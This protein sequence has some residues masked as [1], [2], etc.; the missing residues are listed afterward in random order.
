MNPLRRWWTFALALVVLLLV[1]QI[2]ASFLVRTR[3]VHDFLVAQLSRAFGRPVEVTHFEAQILPSPR[4][5]ATAISVGEDPAFGNEY[6]LRAEGFSAGLRWTG[7]LRGHFEFGTLAFSR[8]SLIL[9]RNAEGRWNLER[10]LPGAKSAGGAV[11]YGPP[12]AT[13]SNHLRTIE[14]DD[15]RVNFKIE[16]DKQAF[17]FTNVAGRVEQID[18]GRW[19]LRLE[20]TPW[21]SGVALQSTGTLRVQ[22]D[23]AG[24]SARLQPAQIQVHW[25][26]A[27]LADL[28]RLWRGQDYGVRGL[29]A[30][31]G[32]LQSGLPDASGKP[33]PSPGA[34][35]VSLQARAQRMHRWDLAERSD[36][37][38]LN[39][40]LKGSF[41][42]DGRAM[43]PARFTIEAPQSNLHGEFFIGSVSA[44]DV[45]VRLDSMGV[46][47]EDL[48]AWYR[49]FQP[50]VND[51]T[52]AQQFF[53]GSATFRGWPPQLESAGFSSPGGALKIPGFLGAVH[54]GP[55][56][57]GRERSRM[58]IEPVKISWTSV[59]L[60]EDQVAPPKRK[61]AA[62]AHSAISIG[63]VH[64]FATGEGGLAIEGR[65]PNSEEVLH[66]AQAFGRTVRHGWDMTGEVSAALQWNWSVG[67]PN[68]WNGRLAANHAQLQVAGLNLPLL[69]EEVELTYKEGR[70]TAE[71]AK[72]Q[73]FG[74]IWHGQIA[75]VGTATL[76]SGDNPRWQFA[77]Q[78][79]KLNAADLD[80]WVGPRARPGWLQRLLGSLLGEANSA[81]N[82][83]ASELL[84]R[85][86]ADG[87]LVIDD[88]TIEKLHLSKL[89]VQGALRELRLDVREAEAQWAGGAVRGAVKAQFAPKVDYDVSVELDRVS[90]AQ[91]PAPFAAR[92]G[93]LASGKLQVTASGVGRDELLQSLAGRAD[94]RLKNAEL[95]GW[96]VPASMADGAAH[97]GVTRWPAGAGLLLVRDRSIVLNDFRLGDGSQLML[98]NGSITFGQTA[99]LSME[100]AGTG[101]R[102]SGTDRVLRISGP[103]DGPHVSVE[104]AGARQPAD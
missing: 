10:W 91:L 51:G 64:D 52:A 88:L 57:G 3:R 30:L 80:R 60:K 18:S 33:Q 6:F 2:G 75:E 99:D 82:I 77:L 56:R 94:L 22:G 25:D 63:L 83:S 17:A 70:R 68:R 29:F 27:S 12:Q 62:E 44:S 72:A 36:N 24:T 11:Y 42:S 32:T 14:F 78:A 65:V 49:A 45:S 98:L 5:D 74:A 19:Q 104:N 26:E 9:V 38:R 96:D 37:P 97:A 76:S 100:N 69:L 67:K 35:T 23:V 87:E 89:R 53:T 50:D 20:A 59:P 8:P 73:G 55:L 21:R 81:S 40:I 28:L 93:G 101:K 13:P 48:L 39:A 54:I 61:V 84:R 79:D 47:S 58:V 16:N 85:V 71:I 41:F 4:L 92:L 15:G 31:D 90:L 66:I 1:A 102:F 46:R 103:L 7:L 95:R 86:S 34:W 43:L